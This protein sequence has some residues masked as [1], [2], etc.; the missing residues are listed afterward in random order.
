MGIVVKLSSL[1][2]KEIGAKFKIIG[3]FS[4]KWLNLLLQRAHWRN[5]IGSWKSKY[6][7]I[8]GKSF[9]LDRAP[10]SDGGY[11]RVEAKKLWFWSDELFYNLFQEF[12]NI[13]FT[14]NSRLQWSPY[15]SDLLGSC[16]RKL[17]LLIFLE[18][19]CKTFTCDKGQ[20]CQN[21]VKMENYFS[22]N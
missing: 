20:K 15:W 16:Y 12:Q 18:F 3:K 5:W 8:F 6:M 19:F 1:Q 10:V 9:N 14:P 17:Y 22:W 13:F 7:Y 11:S 21:M 4:T 2:N